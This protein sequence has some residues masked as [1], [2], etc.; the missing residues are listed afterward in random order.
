MRPGADNDA[1]V[2][3]VTVGDSI[4]SIDFRRLFVLF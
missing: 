2:N 3:R 1:D 4:E